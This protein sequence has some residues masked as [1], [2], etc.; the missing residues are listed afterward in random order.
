MTDDRYHD[1]D[2]GEN[3]ALST[4]QADTRDPGL[5]YRILKR[6]LSG[7]WDRDYLYKYFV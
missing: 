3:L 1:T 5:R 2:I 4:V 6:N 7:R